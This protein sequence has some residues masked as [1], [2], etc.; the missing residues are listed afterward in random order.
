MPTLD[1]TLPIAQR[2][3]PR[4]RVAPKVYTPVMSVDTIA[5]TA[6]HDLL[7]DATLASIRR[8][9]SARDDSYYY[10]DT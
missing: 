4:V 7:C 3:P 6:A 9:L 1:D 2:L 5:T 10:P 8:F